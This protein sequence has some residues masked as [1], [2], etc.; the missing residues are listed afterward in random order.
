MLVNMSARLD[1]TPITR[2]APEIFFAASRAPGGPAPLYVL[3]GFAVVSLLVGI[4]ALA[5]HGRGVGAMFLIVG[6]VLT[7]ITVAVGISTRRLRAHFERTKVLIATRPQTPRITE[8]ANS[9]DPHRR[10]Q[11]ERLARK[12]GREF[13]SGEAG[14]ACVVCVG[15]LDPPAP[16]P[17]LFEP[18][19]ISPT[20]YLGRGWILVM[21]AGGL[22]GLALLQRLN[23]V[24]GLNRVPLGWL[25]GQTYIFAMAI[26]FLVR[27]VWRA[28]LRPT[29]IRVAPGMV[30][31]LRYRFAGQ[32]PEITN[33]PIEAGTLAVALGAMGRRDE[34]VLTSVVLVR[35][36]QSM[37]IPLSQMGA[38][39]DTRQKVWEA[40]MS[41]API[42]PLSET[43]LSG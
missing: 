27:W 33:F 4:F 14:P 6:L 13:T 18:Q 34:T 28:V 8:F 1:S 31:L 19:I 12:F 11:F 41:T 23:V 20:Q 2:A 21:V 37:L 36:D 32:E 16:G 15:A 22:V 42:P 43:G 25:R 24:P 39:A 3:A 40:I 29:Y 38:D 5:L 9:I 35:G 10:S 30:Q 26:F 7:I 17:Y